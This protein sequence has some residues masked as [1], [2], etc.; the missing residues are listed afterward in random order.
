MRVFCLLEYLFIVRKWKKRPACQVHKQ[1]WERIEARQEAMYLME[2]PL[3][4]RGKCIV[5]VFTIIDGKN[6]HVGFLQ[7][8]TVNVPPQ[9]CFV[10][11]SLSPECPYILVCPSLCRINMPD[12]ALIFSSLSSFPLFLI[13]SHKPAWC[14]LPK[15]PLWWLQSLPVWP[16]VEALQLLNCSCEETVPKCQPKSE[17]SY[18]YKS[19][20]KEGW[21]Q[22]AG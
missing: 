10:F 22:A 11:L 12:V 3:T 14:K 9:R 7:T 16:I 8:F 18:K 2:F 15:I 1:S 19:E 13:K 20:T 4:L 6:K 17:Y 5:G 21:Q